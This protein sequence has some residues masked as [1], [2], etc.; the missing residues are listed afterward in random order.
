[1][2]KVPK[3]SKKK[4]IELSTNMSVIDEIVA[5]AAA[6]ET[7]NNPDI[8]TTKKT[9]GRKSKVVTPATLANQKNVANG[10]ATTT[11]S[12]SSN[13]I[14]QLKCGIRD[15][16]EY[17]TLYNNSVTNV[18]EYNP[19]VPPPIMTYNEDEN[20][21]FYKYEK[22]AETT[23]TTEPTAIATQYENTVQN[24][25]ERLCSKCG[26]GCDAESDPKKNVATSNA[27]NS[28]LQ[29]KIK[30]LK[31]QLYKSL[32]DGQNKQSACFWCTFDFETPAFYIP[33]Y[34]TE[35][36]MHCYGSF[37]SPNCAAAYLLNENIN[38]SI[39]F[40]RYSLLNW[41]YSEVDDN[42]VRSIH[43]A[44]NPYYTLQKFCGNLTIQEYR[45]LTQSDNHHLVV[46]ERPLTRI[47]PEL[48][49]ETS[50]TTVTM[51]SRQ[52]SSQPA[53]EE[54]KNMGMGGFRVRKESEKATRASKSEIVRD[55]LGLTNK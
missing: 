4:I 43:P 40:E 10:V 39:R 53:T 51:I 22:T 47:L 27:G 5:A 44:P 6:S 14:L 41:I 11:T 37:C 3:R 26:S 16:R 35:E 13:I 38:D 54:K 9:R 29:Q 21:N 36:T 46:L 45:R 31:I 42:S 30:K 2:S 28:Q 17:N 20:L 1:M 18:T 50:S 49:E 8:D 24:T 33:K 25:E 34:E 48:H 55:R 7:T 23:E 52:Q 15:L 32:N 12:T 19:N